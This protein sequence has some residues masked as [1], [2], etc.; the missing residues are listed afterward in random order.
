MG[1]YSLYRRGRVGGLVQLVQ[2]WACWW[3]YWRVGGR[4][5]I[6]LKYTSKKRVKS[7]TLYPFSLVIGGT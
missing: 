6:T 3:A 1:L 4:G 2:A 5:L 7:V